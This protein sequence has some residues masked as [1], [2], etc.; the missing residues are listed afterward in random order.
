MGKW[1]LLFFLTFLANAG[2]AWAFSTGFNQ[3]WLKNA[4]AHQWEDAYYDQSYVEQLFRLTED[5]KAQIL[6]IWLFEGSW[7]SQF[8]PDKRSGTFKIRL[9]V[10]RNLRHFLKTAKKY[11]VKINLTFLDGNSF[12]YV[13]DRPDLAQF[14]W[15]VF[16]NKYEKQKE[17]YEFAIRPIYQ[18]IEKDFKDVVVQFDIANEVNAITQFHLFEDPKNAMSSFLCKM[19][20]GSPAPVT[21]SLGWGN[22]EELFFAGFLDQACLDF[23]DIHFYNDQGEISQCEKYKL[24]SQ[25][26][27]VLQLGEFGQASADLM[28]DLQSFVT[29][30]FLHKAKECGFQSALAWRLIDHREAPNPEGRFSYVTDDGRPRPAYWIFKDLSF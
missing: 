4:Y 23:Y 5:S 22:A 28:D 24:L 1:I 9:D 6:R 26:N 10:L 20:E 2:S 11:R 8:E 3:A 25:K 17:F 14:W 27:V 19:K 21:A 15:N 7:L 30:Q 29:S 18:L 13:V 16:N 12:Q